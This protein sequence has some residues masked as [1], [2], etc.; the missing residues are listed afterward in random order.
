MNYEQINSFLQ[1]M[2]GEVDPDKQGQRSYRLAIN[3][4]IDENGGLYGLSNMKGSVKLNP[5]QMDDD[6]K[7]VAAFPVTAT[8]DTDKEERDSFVFFTRKDSSGEGKIFL[9]DAEN[10]NNYKLFDDESSPTN[11]RKE[12]MNFGDEI[13]AFQHK[14]GDDWYI[15]W[16][17][18]QNH[19]RHLRLHIQFPLASDASITVRS[20]LKIGNE[21]DL[22]YVQRLFPVDAIVV[23]EVFQEGGVLECAHY[24]FAYRYYDSESRRYSGWSL[25]CQPVPIIIDDVTQVNTNDLQGYLPGA[26][27]SKAIQVRID[28]DHRHHL[29]YDSIQIAVIKSTSREASQ[30]ASLLRPSKTYYGTENTLSLIKYTGNEEVVDTQVLEIVT[31][32]SDIYSCRTLEEH[33]GRL[34]LG[35]ISNWDL[36]VQ[37]PGGNFDAS[38]K[39][40]SLS[41]PGDAMTGATA[42]NQG[43]YDE[44][45]CHEFRQ[46][47]REELYRFGR[48]YIGK[49]GQKAA[50]N[51]F[52]FSSVDKYDS[53]NHAGTWNKNWAS[54]G[55]DWKFPDRQSQEG[56]IFANGSNQIRAMG[57]TLNGLD[58]H[59]DWAF[60]MAI[61]RAEREKDILGQTPVIN[62]V[63]IQGGS[64]Q[65]GYHDLDLAN[66]YWTNTFYDQP[67]SYDYDGLEDYIG[68]KIMAMGAAKNLTYSLLMTGAVER[69]RLHYP[70]WEMQGVKSPGS[71]TDT[72]QHETGYSLKRRNNGVLFVYPLEYLANADGEEYS[73]INLDG[74]EQIKVVDLFALK[75]FN[76]YR[77][78]W[79]G[80][81]NDAGNSQFTDGFQNKYVFIYS[82]AS[83]DSSYYQNGEAGAL[84]APGQAVTASVFPV[85]TAPK[86]PLR[87]ITGY[88]FD[89][90][91]P[92]QPIDRPVSNDDAM[93]HIRYLLNGNG[94]VEKQTANEEDLWSDVNLPAP[95]DITNQRCIA[96]IM[97]SD[98]KLD[99]TDAIN[100]IYD[101]NK[102]I[103]ENY[104]GTPANL[105][106]IF[107]GA[108][109]HANTTYESKKA[110]D[111]S[112][113]EWDLVEADMVKNQIIAPGNEVFVYMA[114][115]I[116]GLGD[117][118]YG[119]KMATRPFYFTGA[120]TPITQG[121]ITDNDELTL[122][123]YG[124]DCYI[125]RASI[126]LRENAPKKGLAEVNDAAKHYIALTSGFRMDAAHKVSTFKHFVEIVDVWVESEING[127]YIFK[128]PD[129]YPFGVESRDSG[130]ET[131]TD[132]EYEYPTGAGL[133]PYIWATRYLYNM[134]YTTQNTQG[135]YS[136]DDENAFSFDKAVSRIQYGPQLTYNSGERFGRFLANDVYD[137]DPSNGEVVKILELA[138]NRLLVVQENAIAVLNLG[139][140]LTEDQD[141]FQINLS[142]G[143]VIGYGQYISQNNE[144]GGDMGGQFLTAI[145]KTEKGVMIYDNRRCKIIQISNGARDISFG[146]VG[147]YIEEE[148]A[149]PANPGRFVSWY[150]NKRKKFGVYRN[151]K[152]K[153][154]VF[155]EGLNVWESAWEWP[156]N[157]EIINIFS[158]ADHQ[159]ALV[160]I[161]G[162]GEIF[163]L[164]ESDDRATVM[165]QPND[166]E[167]HVVLN[168]G[169][170]GRRVNHDDEGKTLVN[171]VANST[172][173]PGEVVAESG[174]PNNLVSPA[175]QF[176]RKRHNQYIANEFRQDAGDPR[177]YGPQIT[178]KIATPSTSNQVRIS[179]LTIHYREK[180]RKNE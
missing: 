166:S 157:L 92:A 63:G 132:K 86:D 119:D 3:K 167:V 114:N 178:L 12:L 136:S 23:S 73:G 89:W 19:I 122:D 149:G 142:S 1:G 141:G 17:D 164:E 117:L 128:P 160:N 38:V 125:T 67:D 36:D 123:V 2:G 127:H 97:S 171:V 88:K 13:D 42:E 103:A 168:R 91:A 59:P 37:D 131:L 28:K 84:L 155:H 170:S 79:L 60:A 44:L 137:M 140:T 9:Y 176:R 68:P 50:T 104:D 151:N 6:Y 112:D 54:E 49:F 108:T 65:S 62:G 158:V 101:P 139:Q 48:V 26:P 41:I 143:Q 134:G 8:Y 75:A 153:G 113:G 159:Y 116:K 129:T 173:D 66:D 18:G 146:A 156:L 15:Y 130:N 5:S 57:L 174:P 172:E 111:T 126:K 69:S 152:G 71:G 145:K 35:G 74:S 124:G 165:D 43:F 76:A 107:P 163:K 115:I 78:D 118:R 56:C 161:D 169:S 90:G 110:D 77:D 45:H 25:I 144:T 51:V 175:A 21:G 29:Y 87:I 138:R 95:F 27:T 100:F 53:G 121:N 61:V 94:L 81:S 10:D 80:D 47:F 98:E 30:T 55:T 180:N 40:T 83:I 102:F 70:G 7:I 106:D 148:M 52:D 46:Y 135:V 93:Q 162:A 147:N 24:Q 179:S 39:M 31:D 34:F 22:L 14:D 109:I 58:N 33:N 96:L 11:A 85:N 32:D 150:D 4:I 99:D 64:Y 105:S 177:I 133:T 20:P 82:Q 16:A 72:V 154:L 120:Y